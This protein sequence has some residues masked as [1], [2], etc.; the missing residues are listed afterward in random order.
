M[1]TN[2]ARGALTEIAKSA[3][4]EAWQLAFNDGLGAGHPLGR[5]FLD[6]ETE[7]KQSDVLESIN[8]QKDNES[9]TG[10]GDGMA[11]PFQTR[12]QPWMLACFGAEIAADGVERNH[13]FL[14][15]ALELVQ[16]CGCTRS[17]AHQ[18]VDYVFSRPVGEKRQEVGGVMVTLAAL[19]LAQSLDMHAAGETEL[20]RVWTKVEQIRAK[21]A[22]KPKHSPLP[23][24]QTAPVLWVRTQTI[25]DAAGAPIGMDEP[26]L[27]FGEAHPAGDGWYPFYN[28]AP[29]AWQPI[30]TAPE[31][32]PL[33]VGWLDSTDPENPERHDFDCKEDGVWLQHADRYDHFCMVA[34]PGSRGPKEDAPYLVWMP[35]PSFATQAL[36]TPDTEIEAL[37]DG[38][39]ENTAVIAA[40]RAENSQRA[41]IIA[42][43]VQAHGRAWPEQLT[44]GVMFYEGER[45]TKTEFMA[46][47]RA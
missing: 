33:V 25:D 37:F 5:S 15:E 47:V 41:E 27:K 35:L 31:G 26:E 11:T 16:A 2:D 39:A 34:P 28:P 36:P 19:C 38:R 30:S 21:Q 8:R 45:I 46:E 14:E 10:K 43:A 12:V 40:S 3:W 44:S 4:D 22:A 1:T 6:R 13:R 17:E 29:V 23:Q 18:L 9:A 32:V 42:R 7:W 24:H 20:A